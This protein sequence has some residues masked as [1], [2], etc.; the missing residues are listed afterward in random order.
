DAGAT[1]GV[2]LKVRCG[3]HAGVDSR[4]DN[5]FYGN[6]VNRAA[7][8]MSVGH[9]G[10]IPA[11]PGVAPLVSGGLAGGVTLGELGAVRL[12]DLTQPELVYQVVHSMLRQQFPALRSLEAT[13]N[14]LPQHITSFIGREHELAEVRRQLQ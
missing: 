5:D 7:R 2:P 11:S 1:A 3:L 9:G 8:V 10:Q 12:R 6:A 4:R 13:P 14:N